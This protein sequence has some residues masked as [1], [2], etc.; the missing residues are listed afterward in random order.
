MYG[1]IDQ[2]NKIIGRCSIQID[3][4][5]D[6]GDAQIGD[7]YINGTIYPAS[8]HVDEIPTVTKNG[9]TWSPDPEA[10]TRRL[11]LIDTQRRA[12]YAAESDPLFFK[13]QRGEVDAGTWAA[14]VAE[15]KARFSK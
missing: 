15:I 13:E 1:N 5:P 10:E 14:K 2:N 9:V 6:I 11:A 3:I 7:Y 12:A 8:E 4:M